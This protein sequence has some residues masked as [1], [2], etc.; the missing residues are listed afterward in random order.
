M[1]FN[2]RFD[3]PRA[4]THGVLVL[5]LLLT[6]GCGGGDDEP[7]P[8]DPS[9]AVSMTV[10]Y[11]T[12]SEVV[13]LGTLTG[14]EDG[15]LCLVPLLDVVNEAGLGFDPDASYYDFVSG[16]GFRPTQVDCV[17]VD[18]TTLKLGWVDR[19]TGTLVWD[20]SLGMR[21][22]YSVTGAVEIAAYDTPWPEVQ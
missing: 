18:A 8:C 6:P 5:A 22:C 11:D 1:S 12:D 9:R 21:G 10:S 17:T 2:R 16:D 15:D 13:D 3:P 14:S 4:S 7:V 19:V 20:A